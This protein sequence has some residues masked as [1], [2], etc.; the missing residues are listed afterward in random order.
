MSRLVRISGRVL[1]YITELTGITDSLLRAEGTA[2]DEV[3]DEAWGF[4]RGTQ[5][6]AHNAGFNRRFLDAFVLRWNARSRCLSNFC[7]GERTT[8]CQC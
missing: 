4:I 6:Y 1:W 5:S 8:A 3:L 7:P 2:L